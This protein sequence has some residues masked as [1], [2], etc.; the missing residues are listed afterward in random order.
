MT[1]DPGTYLAAGTDSK[2]GI[3]ARTR[4]MPVR[5]LAPALRIRSGGSNPKSEAR[6]PDGPAAQ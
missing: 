4:A 2:V 5:P 6:L 1:G 3:V